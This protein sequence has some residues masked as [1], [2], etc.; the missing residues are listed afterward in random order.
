VPCPRNTL[1]ASLDTAMQMNFPD[2]SW[3]DYYK[4][5]FPSFCL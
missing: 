4:P 2:S 5:C 1:K 3:L